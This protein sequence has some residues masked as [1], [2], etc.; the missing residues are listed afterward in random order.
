M[1]KKTRIL[2]IPKL[3]LFLIPTNSVQPVPILAPPVVQTTDSPIVQPRADEELPELVITELDAIAQTEPIS[4]AIPTTTIQPAQI[5]SVAADIL[6]HRLS[7]PQ[8]EE[9]KQKFL[10]FL[11]KN[12]R[13]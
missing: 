1:V 12:K 4:Q 13:V 9:K 11:K 6:P 8:L 3:H 5:E 2:K 10:E 7:S